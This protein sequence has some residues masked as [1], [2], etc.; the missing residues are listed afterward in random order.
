MDPRASLEGERNNEA[1]G[2]GKATKAT[3]AEVAKRY[4]GNKRKRRGECQN[5]PS[6]SDMRNAA[7]QFGGSAGPGPH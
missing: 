5:M 2:S 1:E 4:G 6:Q 7:P 3:R